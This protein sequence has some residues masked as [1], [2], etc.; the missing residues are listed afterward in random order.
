NS[1]AIKK[2]R[3]GGRQAYAI[4]TQGKGKASEC[5]ECGQCENACPQH[6]EIISLLKECRKME[7]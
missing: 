1:E 2:S 5:V 4:A 7:G 3:D 6:L